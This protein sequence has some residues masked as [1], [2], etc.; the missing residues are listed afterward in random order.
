[1]NKLYAGDIV[2]I[3]NAIPNVIAIYLTGS[4]LRHLEV[5]N[6]DTD[7]Y[8]ITSPTSDSLLEAKVIS[9][10]VKI[11]DELDCQ[12]W[13]V[14]QFNK[15]VHKCNMNLIEMIEEEPLFTNDKNFTDFI[16]GARSVILD[17]NRH[18]LY[19]NLIGNAIQSIKYMEKHKIQSKEFRKKLAL[20]EYYFIYSRL[21]FNKNMISQEE[22]L[23]L[24]R[25]K[26]GT[27]IPL[28]MSRDE[29]YAEINAQIE[30]Y[31]EELETIYD[32]NETP[33]Y[34]GFEE[35]LKAHIMQFIRV[36]TSPFRPKI[37]GAIKIDTNLR[38]LVGYKEGKEAFF[39]FVAPY[40][41]DDFRLS[42]DIY[43]QFPPQLVSLSSSWVQGF[44]DELVRH[45][46]YFGVEKYLRIIRHPNDLEE[47][48]K[49]RIF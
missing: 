21:N 31:S 9:K 41:S 48:F 40:L 19:K 33:E 16:K 29:A 23:R 24:Q 32:N 2:K 38:A 15:I 10:V 43:I 47:Q 11:D 35:N 49:H 36:L 27:N 42:S 25:I 34:F 6:S 13:D 17:G 8:V 5:V 22:L 14:L 45:N 46:G 20:C 18:R 30:T 12:V 1:M 3:L 39:K 4:R 37:E 7:Y 44:I 28:P 26:N